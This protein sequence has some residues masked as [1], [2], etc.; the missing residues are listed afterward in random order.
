MR[1]RLRQVARVLVAPAV[2]SALLIV[3]LLLRVLRYKGTVRL[4]VT[5]SPSR[6]MGRPGPWAKR[7]ARLVGDSQHRWDG[8]PFRC[9]HRAVLIWWSMRWM[10][11]EAEVVSGATQDATGGVLIHAWAESGGVPLGDSVANVAR[12][13]RLWPELGA[14]ALAPSRHNTRHS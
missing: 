6:S 9:I 3:A 14:A 1:R 4:L 12:Y 5:L 11:V 8:A 7:V 10:G 13:T 2:G